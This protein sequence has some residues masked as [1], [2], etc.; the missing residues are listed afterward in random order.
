MEN[1]MF[2]M[3]AFDEKIDLLRY[4]NKYVRKKVV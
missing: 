3:R 4:I 2:F 1:S